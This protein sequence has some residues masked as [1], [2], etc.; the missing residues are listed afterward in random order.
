MQSQK[1]PFTDNY[2]ATNPQ[3]ANIRDMMFDLERRAH[4]TGWD[5]PD[6]NPRV[7]AVAAHP[8][9]PD[10]DSLWADPLTEHLHTLTEQFNG[11][12]GQA[13][14]ALAADHEDMRRKGAFPPD[15]DVLPPADNG[16]RFHG[17]GFRCE[18][19]GTLSDDPQGIEMALHHRL[20]EYAGRTELRTVYFYDRD[21]NFWTVSRIRSGSPYIQVI[22]HDGHP[23]LDSMGMIGNALSRMVNAIIP[24]PVPVRAR[25]RP[26]GHPLFR[27]TN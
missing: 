3:A 14:Q 26:G 11:N 19:W 15:Q 16:W 2:C 13:L 10:V 12:V 5:G 9:V 25:E 6:S 4:A 23:D 7:F 20:N 21:G 27:L 18:A 24:D 8:N 1:D 17:L 22:P